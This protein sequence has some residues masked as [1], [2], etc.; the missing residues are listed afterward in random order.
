MKLTIAAIL[1]AS[2][3]STRSIVA[4]P[5]SHVS[6]NYPEDKATVVFVVPAGYRLSRNFVGHHDVDYVIYKGDGS[7]SRVVLTFGMRMDRPFPTGDVSKGR[8]LG[9]EVVWRSYRGGPLYRD[10]PYMELAEVE[11]VLERRTCVRD[12]AGVRLYLLT[13]DPK[14]FPELRAIAQ[15]ME[16]RDAAP[17]R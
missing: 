16:L 15:S 8:V 12:L 7:S 4:V 6:A 1:M 13:D 17:C 9:A 5:L 3:A 11:S 10:G 2:C 14:S